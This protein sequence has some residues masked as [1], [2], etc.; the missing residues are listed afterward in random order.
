M[1]R[2]HFKWNDK[3]ENK[4]NVEPK[5]YYHTQFNAWKVRMEMDRE[6]L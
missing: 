4:D 3:I 5:I 6:D 2:G 1:G